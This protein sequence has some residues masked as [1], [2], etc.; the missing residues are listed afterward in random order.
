MTNIPWVIRRE[1]ERDFVQ[2]PYSGDNKMFTGNVLDA[3]AFATQ[4]MAIDKILE[5]GLEEECLPEPF[6]LPI[7]IASEMQ[8]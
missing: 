5:M 7:N 3:Q 1:K 8:E 4:Q 6:A 2:A